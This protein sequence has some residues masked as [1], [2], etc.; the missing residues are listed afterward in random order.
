[1]TDQV[2]FDIDKRSHVPVLIF[3]EPSEL[4][5][6]AARQV[7]TLIE[8]KAAAGARAILGLPTGSTPIGV[9]QELVRMHRE[10][11]LDFSNVVTFNIDEYVPMQPDSLQSYHRFMHENLFDHINVPE[12][13]I[14]IPRGD[15][16]PE[17]MDQH[18]AEYERAIQSAGGLDLLLLGIGR[19]GHI[20]FNEPGST[21]EDR[22]RL[23]V[24]DEITRK[25][26]ASDFFEEKYVPREAITMGVGTILDA[27]ELILLATGSAKAAIV[28]RAVEGPITSMV[29]ASAIQLHPNCKVIVDEEAAAE[30]QGRHYYDFVF[31]NEPEWSAYR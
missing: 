10:D 25:D 29:S 14:H 20:G 23:I 28:A 17:A 19:S 24:L 9:Y 21:P 8:A 4:A 30:L 7:R 26:A 31:A 12:G 22:T 13:N 6:Q 27:R 3:D 5:R 11:G 2:A 1:M 15:L 18:A 16:P